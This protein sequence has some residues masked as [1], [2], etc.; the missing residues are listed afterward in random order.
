MYGW[1]TCL[2]TGGEV[3]A[4]VLPGAPTTQITAARAV[5]VHR[6]GRKNLPRAFATVTTPTA[7]R[8]PTVAGKR[9]RMPS[10]FRNALERYP[11]GP[12]SRPTW[13]A[14]LDRPRLPFGPPLV[15]PQGS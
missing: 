12:E 9:H 3:A 2:E 7:L 1:T 14:D 5:A 4:R 10:P 8:L 13:A 11:G 6:I 15:A